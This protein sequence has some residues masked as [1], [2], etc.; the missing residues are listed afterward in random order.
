MVPRRKK[1][2]ALVRRPIQ[3]AR[4][5]TA[6]GDNRVPGRDLD[7]EGKGMRPICCRWS[8]EPTGYAQATDRQVV[9]L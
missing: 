3:P 7:V 4:G 9:R 1:P 5:Y 2:H 6:L 8:E